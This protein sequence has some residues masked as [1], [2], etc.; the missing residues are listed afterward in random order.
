LL[1]RKPQNVVFLISVRALKVRV[2]DRHHL[3]GELL[4]I[5]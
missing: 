2:H 4:L 3:S 5:D 1:G